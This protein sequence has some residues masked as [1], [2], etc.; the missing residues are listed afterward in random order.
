MSQGGT[1]RDLTA[2]CVSAVVPVKQQSKNSR[3]VVPCHTGPTLRYLHWPLV[4]GR[5]P[6]GTATRLWWF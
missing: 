3:Q 4:V 1:L 2:G 6:Y 5:D